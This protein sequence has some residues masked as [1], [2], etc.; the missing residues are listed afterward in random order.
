MIIRQEAYFLAY[1][2]RSHIQKLFDQS[3]DQEAA[4]SSVFWPTPGAVKKFRLIE[5]RDR[6][7]EGE[8]E[9]NLEY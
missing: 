3:C 7:R 2:I 4:S 8:R 6:N 5:K 9:L 1:V